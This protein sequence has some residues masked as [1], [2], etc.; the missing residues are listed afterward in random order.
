MGI[1]I[2]IFVVIDKENSDWG[3]LLKVIRFYKLTRIDIIFINLFLFL[4]FL[5]FGQ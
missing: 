2:G 4:L 3:S 1:R 5:I